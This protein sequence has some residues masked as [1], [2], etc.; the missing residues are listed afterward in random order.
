ML[1]F[2]GFQ[3]KPA[4]NVRRLAQDFL[5]IYFSRCFLSD[6]NF[7]AI[8]QP[9]ATATENLSNA[10]DDDGWR[11]ILSSSTCRRSTGGLL[12][13]ACYQSRDLLWCKKK[14]FWV[15]S[16]V[17]TTKLKK[18]TMLGSE[19]IGIWTLVLLKWT[20]ILLS[21][22]NCNFCFNRLRLIGILNV[23]SMSLQFTF[24]TRQKLV[25]NANYY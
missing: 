14:S 6:C 3:I 7:S 21:S 17:W 15:R 16:W 5:F 9:P 20:Q 18:K 25:T 8:H 2:N 23:T 11:E 1:N 12:L 22:K 10:D 13:L 4:C 24:G 19:F